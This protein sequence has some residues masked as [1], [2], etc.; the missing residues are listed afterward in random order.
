[1][2]EKTQQP[3]VSP[4]LSS[5]ALSLRHAVAL[6]VG[7]MSPAG[8]IFFNTIPQAGLVGAALPLCFAIGFIVVLLLANQVSEL[9][10]EISS[11]GAAYTIVAQAFGIRLGFIAGWVSIFS[12]LLA[13]PLLLVVT[14]ASLQ[15]LALRWFGLS[16]P[17]SYWFIVSIGIAF[18]L[19][20]FGIRQSLRVDLTFIIFE[21]V[22]CLVLAIAILFK[23][24]AQG[25][26]TLT[27]FTPAV[28][29]PQGSLVLGV[30]LA[31]FSFTGFEASATLGEET[32]EPKKNI[33]RAVL[34]S[35]VIVGLFYVLMAYVATIGYGTGH[36]QQ[37]AQDG[38][39]FDTLARHYVGTA[40]VPFIDIAGIISF[41]AA[42]LAALNGSA[43][44]AY[45][46]G[47]EGL[48][49][50]WLAF[51]H[52][53]H[54]TPVNAV[55]LVAL[56]SLVIGL[57]LGF[58]MTPLGAFGFLS[59]VVA[60][61]ALVAYTLINLSCLGYFLR[62]NRQRF[63]ILRHAIIPIVASLISIT[64]LIAT[65]TQPGPAPLSYTPYVVLTWIVLGIALLLLLQWKKP[66]ELQQAGSIPISNE[67]PL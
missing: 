2:E 13:I 29:P 38:A 28:V 17:W 52:P 27:P 49:P 14:S 40:F 41:L 5:N 43:R 65:I 56:L 21:I 11:S 24:G 51:T 58:M 35:M 63:N 47:R 48:L 20:Y 1:M 54:K 42:A 45:A 4:T 37:F 15:D 22:V 3:A 61:F 53:T 18:A 36:M 7:L 23:A 31:I 32:R 9:T 8:S 34:G 19:S 6:S 39:P 30:I 57:S 12:Y 64:L 50:G 66:E 59:I 44:V 33:P 10:K 60:L 55:L 25:Q 67:Y 46:I 26:L 16:I 62:K